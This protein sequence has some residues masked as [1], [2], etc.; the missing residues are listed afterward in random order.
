M[1][2]T[3]MFVKAPNVTYAS[4]YTRLSARALSQ[5]QG[6]SVCGSHANMQSG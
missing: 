6:P 3:T 5:A 2:I 4:V 1:G